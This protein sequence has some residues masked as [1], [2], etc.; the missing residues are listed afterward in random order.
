MLGI[1]S[2]L[3]GYPAESLGGLERGVSPLEMANAYATIVSGGYR[4]RPTAIKKVRFPDGRVEQ[5]SKLPRR[6]RV[7]AH[8]GLRHERHLR[9]GQDP[10]AERQ[11]GTGTHAQ[12]G[13]PAPARPGP[14]TRTRTRG[15]SASP[16]GL[17]TAVWV[18]Y[19]KSRVQM[20]GLYI[21]GR[22]VDGGTY[23]ADIWGNYMRA[24]TGGSCGEFRK[25][26]KPFQAQPFFGKYSK[27]GG[28]S[29]P[30]DPNGSDSGVGFDST[31]D[32]AEPPAAFNPDAYESPPQ[33]T[34]R[35]ARPR[36]PRERGGGGG[37]GGGGGD[38]EPGGG[39]AAPTE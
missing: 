32:G 18:G 31:P 1:K 24:V 9:G 10:R 5:G 38:V 23:P 13:C 36:A 4:S 2:V 26:S 20:N 28:A 6:F 19:P 29:D 25:P 8:E 39:T 21:G 22:N 15:S 17:S 16:G 37:G 30:D 3:K 12:I 35:S 14:P 11:G 34:P 27:R 7:Q 33:R